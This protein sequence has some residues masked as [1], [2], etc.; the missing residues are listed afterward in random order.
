[1]P[2]EVAE[3]WLKYLREELP[4]V[5]FKCSTQ[6][7]GANLGHRRG[8]SSAAGADAALKGSE[9]LGAPRRLGRAGRALKHLWPGGSSRGGAGRGQ[10]RRGLVQGQARSPG[11]AGAQ[12]ARRALLV[13]E[14]TL[15][16]PHPPARPRSPPLPAR[17]TGADSLLQL[18]KNYARN[19][20]LKA[21]ITVGVVGLPNVGKSSLINSLKRARV[22]QVRGG[23]GRGGPAFQGW[24]LGAEVRG[25]SAC[26]GW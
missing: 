25:S 15:A 18:L 11:A 22:A 24:W 12:G 16:C 2:R 9:C 21:S 13:P 10:G 8:G 19:A 3:R 26:Q 17:P 5:A 7:Q 20:G 4:A 6:K 23:A 14:A 1:M